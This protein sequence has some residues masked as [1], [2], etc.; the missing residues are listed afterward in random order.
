MGPAPGKK[1]GARGR[2][3]CYVVRRQLR[4]RYLAV[5]H[6]KRAIRAKSD[7]DVERINDALKMQLS[8]FW[9]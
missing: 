3:Q 2:L 1:V 9:S 7:R 5:H 4:R 8:V 6:A